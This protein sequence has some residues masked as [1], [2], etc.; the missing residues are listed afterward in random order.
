MESPSY[1]SE[2][3]RHPGRNVSPW[4]LL[5]TFE[6]WSGP[7][8]RWHQSIS[9]RQ[10]VQNAEDGPKG[11]FQGTYVTLQA[12]LKGYG[13]PWPPVPRDS[14]VWLI[15]ERPPYELLWASESVYAAL[16]RTEGEL[17]EQ[18]A[19][20]ALR[21]GEDLR[22]DEPE[23]AAVV[24]RVLHGLDATGDWP[25]THLV[26]ADGLWL[27]VSMHFRYGSESRTLYVQAYAIGA[28]RV[29]PNVPKT[30]A[31]FDGISA[32]TRRGLLRMLDEFETR[33]GDPWPGIPV[34]TKR[35]RRA[36]RPAIP[37]LDE[38]P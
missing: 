34:E 20:E 12:C 17:L 19:M 37:G 22:R 6:A 30:E 33:A 32:P 5:T 13:L 3:G 11:P 7:R 25:E 15:D 27:P 1:A 31:T 24:G 36:A 10:F 9:K 18:P 8:Y 38:N 28:P 16:L 29:P 21:P 14:L 2:P 4:E 23:H 35:R 26:R